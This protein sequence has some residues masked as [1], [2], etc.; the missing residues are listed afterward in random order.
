MTQLPIL[1]NCGSYFVFQKLFLSERTLSSGVIV[2]RN[3]V[4]EDA[5]KTSGV[6]FVPVSLILK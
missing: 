4:N 1:P 5:T 6:L 3:V 2:W